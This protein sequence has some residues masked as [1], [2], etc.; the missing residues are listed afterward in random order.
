MMMDNDGDVLHWGVMV[1]VV[2]VMMTVVILMTTLV[3]IVERER[4]VKVKK[5]W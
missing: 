2:L 3:L 4:R 5:N 1:L